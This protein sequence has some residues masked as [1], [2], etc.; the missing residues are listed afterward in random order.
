M[1]RY[2][3]LLLFIFNSC[4]KSPQSNIIEIDAIKKVLATQQKYWNDGDIDGFMVGYWNSNKLKF[5]WVNRIE[6]GWNNL[7]EKYKISYPNKES[8][9]EFS[10]EILDVKL[11]SDTTAIL[12]GKW[13][14]IR[15]NDNPKGSF[16]YILNK[17]E[18]NWL[19]ISDY[20]TGEY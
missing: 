16:S 15:K 8:M 2:I 4:A 3:A 17:I 13:E 11:T 7:L 6:Y 9:G 20:T 1:L 10:F 19:I 5:S 14:L 12:D 18:N